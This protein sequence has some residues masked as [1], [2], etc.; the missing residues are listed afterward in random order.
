MGRMYN[1][2]CIYCGRSPDVMWGRIC[3]KCRDKKEKE[4]ARER[5]HRELLAALKKIAEIADA[6]EVVTA[7]VETDGE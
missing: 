6:T 3:D 5:R 1:V 4:D 7:S 2:T